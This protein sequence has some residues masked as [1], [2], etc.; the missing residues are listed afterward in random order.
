MSFALDGFPGWEGSSLSAQQP[1]I[2][3]IYYACFRT[4]A[5]IKPDATRFK[6]DILQAMSRDGFKVTQIQMC[7]LTK[8]QAGAFYAEHKGKPFFNNLVELMTSGCCIV[9]ELMRPNAILR[10]RD[11]LGPTNT[12]QAQASAPNSIR[13]RFG[14]DQTKN[15]CHGSDSPES[16]RR[17]LEF[18]FPRDTSRSRAPANTAR[19]SN[20]TL[21]V[22]KP[23]AV[24]DD[25]LAQIVKDIDGAGFNILALKSFNLEKSDCEE[26]LEVYKGVV[27]EYGDMVCEMS[28][29]TCVALEIDAQGDPAKFRAF[30]GPADPEIARHL[31]PQTLRAKYGKSKVQNAVHVTDL[32]DDAP[33]EV[34]YFFR[35]LS[36]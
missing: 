2:L 20:S 31:R 33:L 13:A 4:L 29:G 36:Q 28:S 5:I 34:E 12:Q 22:V 21:A 18:F 19:L 30:V 1:V 3:V 24:K 9:M 6:G 26:F 10:W 27:N 17:E 16:A 25:Q 7:H 35:I 8:D 11:L 23:Q 32:V 14:T 15:A